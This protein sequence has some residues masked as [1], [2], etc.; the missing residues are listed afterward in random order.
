MSIS[1]NIY[2]MEYS[3]VNE[4]VKKITSVGLIE[5]KSIGKKKYKMTFYYSDNV[6]GNTV[7]WWQT[8]QN[9]FKDD[10][11]EPFNIFHFGLLLCYKNKNPEHCY[12]V[13]LGKSHFYLNKF[14]EH[15]FGIKVA[16]RIANDENILLK[17]SRY[18][19]GAKKQD[20]ASYQKFI[21]GSY[22][23]GESV[24]HL[25]TKASLEEI[26][27]S[28][29]I[30]FADSIQ[31]DL[32]KKPEELADIFNEI[33]VSLNKSGEIEFPKLE[34]VLD[35]SKT[36]ELDETLLNAILNKEAEVQ[37]DEMQS[38]GT[39]IIFVDSD[40]NY[41]LFVKEK[42]SQKWAVR[43]PVINNISIDD[44]LNFINNEKI[45]DLNDIFVK[46]VNEVQGSYTLPLKK[47][48]CFTVKDQD[49]YFYLKNGD[50][51]SFNA[52]FMKFLENSLK[53][54]DFVLAD[55]I[56]EK[57]FLAWKKEKEQLI[58]DK[59]HKNKLKYRE[60]YF[61]EKMAKDKTFLLMDRN[62]KQIKSLNNNGRDYKVEMADLYLN[63]ELISVKI[64]DKPHDIIYN[65]EQ[66]KTSAQMINRGTVTFTKPLTHMSIW[67]SMQKR[68]NDIT[69]I[70]SIQAL[71]AI[72][73][74]KEMIEGMGLKV[75]VYYSYHDKS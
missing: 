25:K 22:L 73:S 66:S 53:S 69:G 71:L 56:R 23:P 10:V 40:S 54:I 4:L 14:I 15:D 42:D 50:W 18:F 6:K 41:K 13:S 47:L 46:V 29:N 72:Q 20:V 17:K 48:L 28:K 58:K 7:W 27:G 12:L 37:I 19:C 5:Q 31:L 16:M 33:D 70:N 26:W 65:V 24:E 62:L 55:D 74:W 61:N 67:L 38:F 43:T 32:E 44:V 9:F 21:P 51:C 75:R 34:K 11:V 2:R 64:S 68:I 63:K 39:S 8:F 59:K 36:D 3:K 57:D 60:Y 49:E 1:Y 30:I 45:N 35:E 52:T